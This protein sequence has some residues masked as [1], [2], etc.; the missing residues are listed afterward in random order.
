[1]LHSGR[2]DGTEDKF[3]AIGRNITHEESAEQFQSHSWK[4]TDDKY[5]I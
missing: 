4:K 1:M 5:F 3:S 2:L